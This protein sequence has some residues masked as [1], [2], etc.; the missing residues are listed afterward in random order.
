MSIVEFAAAVFI[1]F[2][3]VDI[4]GYI[5]VLLFLGSSYLFDKKN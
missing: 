3:I 1:G 2:I 5:L 4:I